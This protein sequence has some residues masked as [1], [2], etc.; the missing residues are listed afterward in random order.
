MLPN[1]Y[2]LLPQVRNSNYKRGASSIISRSRGMEFL[3]G[4]A[5]LATHQRVTDRAPLD[6]ASATRP[7][8]A[9]ERSRILWW[10][11]FSHPLCNRTLDTTCWAKDHFGIVR[12]TLS[13]ASLSLAPIREVRSS[14]VLRSSAVPLL[15]AF[16]RTAII[17]DNSVLCA[18]P[19]ACG[20]PRL[21]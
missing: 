5:R 10:G 12:A 13:A 2:H 7:S 14:T 3:Q 1:S 16:R 11:P 15:R 20:A 18:T 19:R 9:M 4:S 17:P 21:G 8:G 6:T